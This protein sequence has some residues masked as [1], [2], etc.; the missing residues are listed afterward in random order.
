MERIQNHLAV[1][2]YGKTQSSSLHFWKKAQVYSGGKQLA[3]ETCILIARDNLKGVKSAT[4]FFI[5]CH[6]IV[7]SCKQVLFHTLF[8]R[9]QGI[10][11]MFST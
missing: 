4:E 11:R 9:L 7:H 6:F 3:Y 1:L 10:N 5:F 8:T 2:E